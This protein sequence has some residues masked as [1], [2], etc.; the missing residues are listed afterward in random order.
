MMIT[1]VSIMMTIIVKMLSLVRVNLILVKTI[2]KLIRREI[3]FLLV[4]YEAAIGQ[5][6]L[7]INYTPL[8]FSALYTLNSTNKSQNCPEGLKI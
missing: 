4:R 5:A 6:A 3:L 8:F 1:V 7:R 2:L